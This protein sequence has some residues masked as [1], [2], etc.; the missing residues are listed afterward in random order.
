LSLSSF[1]TADAGQAFAQMLACCASRRFAAAMTAGRPYPSAAAAEQAVETVFSSLTWADVTEGMDGHPRI[2]ARV[3]GP[4]AAEQ[5]GVAD[6]TRAAL[7]AG[8]AAYEDRFGHVFLICASGLSGAEM[9]AALRRRLDND[10]A[11]ERGQATTELRKITVLRVRKALA[12]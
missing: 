1:N 8:N 11:A 9:L 12:G 4:S 6:D 5:S 7:A 10:A 3:A 2:G